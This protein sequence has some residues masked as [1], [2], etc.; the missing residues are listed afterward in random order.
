MPLPRSRSHCNKP[1]SRAERGAN[2]HTLACSLM[3]QAL[4]EPEPGWSKATPGHHVEANARPGFTQVD[5]LV[6]A[7]GPAS[8]TLFQC[9]DEGINREACHSLVACRSADSQLS[10]DALHR[11]PV[12]VL[13][14]S[15]TLVF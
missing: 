7:K 1:T 15:H 11:V 2:L 9:G 4:E 6:N 5:T 12:L 3:C 13:H 10:L 14:H 8:L